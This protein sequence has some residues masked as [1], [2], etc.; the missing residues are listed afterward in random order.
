[1]ED[2][3]VARFSRSKRTARGFAAAGILFAAQFVFV[4]ISFPELVLSKAPPLTSLAVGLCFGLFILMPLGC[5]NL[6]FRRTASCIEL[7]ENGIRNPAQG[8]DWLR[9]EDITSIRVNKLK[10]RY[11]VISESNS[12]PV[13]IGMEVNEVKVV[14]AEVL[15]RAES[16]RE[17]ATGRR[18]FQC[19][20]LKYLF[21]A[22]GS[23]GILA[24]LMVNA[25][26]KFFMLS[27]GPLLIICALASI[28]STPSRLRIDDTHLRIQYLFWTTAI[29]IAD[30]EQVRFLG[31]RLH[32]TFKPQ[33]STQIWVKRD[34]LDAFLSV[35]D[36]WQNT[37]AGS[38]MTA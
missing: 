28:I 19:R 10:L 20:S 12:K 9:W 31:D 13:E 35:R 2:R 18:D 29:P 26:F 6:A 33:K 22:L 15:A 21:S 1:M 37:R 14:V 11:D 25:D 23:V 3:P 24:Y 17:T 38:S 16:L 34:C 4:A 32:I 30:I 5:L 8:S 7:G 36:A 27:F